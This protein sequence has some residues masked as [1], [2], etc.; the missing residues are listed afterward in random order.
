[1]KQ[2]PITSH[3][4]QLPPTYNREQYLLLFKLTVTAEVTFAYKTCVLW[5]DTIAIYY[6]SLI[7]VIYEISVVILRCLS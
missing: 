3:K 6:F 1:M 4:A 5:P 7:Y 2:Y